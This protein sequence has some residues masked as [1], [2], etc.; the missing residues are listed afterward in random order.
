[1]ASPRNLSP[2]TAPAFTLLELLAV[3]AI[4]ALL[5]GFVLG[6]GRRATESAKGVRARAELAALAAAL[7][8]YRR[9]YGDYPQTG[10]AARL[11][12]S[13]LGR[14]G[15]AGAAVN[16]RTLLETG[17]FTTTDGSDP[18]ANAAAELADPW[19]RPYV[20]TYKSPPAGWLNPGFVLYSVGPDGTGAPGLLGGGWIDTAAPANADNI[21]A[22]RN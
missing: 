3:L 18:V 8:S 7:E 11:L 13:L 6:S 20:Y 19:G 21:Y 9:A 1:M 10:D 12:Q 22:N 14:L 15:P 2:R 4:V 5:A 16:G 17:R